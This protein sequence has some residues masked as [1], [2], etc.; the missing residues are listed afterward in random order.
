MRTVP[1]YLGT[2]AISKNIRGFSFALLGGVG[3]GFSGACA[4]FLFSNYGADP[5]WISSVRM[6]CAGAELCVLALVIARG[7][8][9]AMWRNPRT[10]AQ[11]V[12]FSIFGLAACQITYLFAIQNSNAGTATVIQYIGPVLVVFYLCARAHRRPTTREVIAM[13]LVVSG[14]YL[15]ATH[16]NPATMVLTS[17]FVLGV[18]LGSDVR[19]VL[20]YTAQTH[21]ALRQRAGCSRRLAGWRHRVFRGRAIVDG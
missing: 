8:F 21:A 12:F 10:V 7:P 3:W 17:G 13:A 5:L 14:T 4:Q 11:L 16:G 18:N 9:L 1:W 15:I 20:A 19:H 6:I 2:V